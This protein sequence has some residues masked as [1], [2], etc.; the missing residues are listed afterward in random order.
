MAI[1]S[2]LTSAAGCGL[3]F[4]A[5]IFQP[6]ACKRRVSRLPMSPRP[7]NP[8]RVLSLLSAVIGMSVMLPPYCL[9]LSFRLVAIDPQLYLARVLPLRIDADSARYCVL[10]AGWC[11]LLSDL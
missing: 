9:R 6:A 8:T 3:R 1:P 5:R 2:L 11:R 4:H 10:L 7:M